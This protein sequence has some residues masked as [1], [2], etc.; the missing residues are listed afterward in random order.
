MVWQISIEDQIDIK[1][2]FSIYITTKIKTDVTPK[3]AD[4]PNEQTEARL[5]PADQNTPRPSQTRAEPADSSSGSE[6]EP[7][8]GTK[9]D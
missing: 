1:I 2:K 6:A 3:K 8:L 9:L 5:E 7:A 4:Q